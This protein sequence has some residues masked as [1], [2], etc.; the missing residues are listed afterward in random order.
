MTNNDG[1]EPWSHSSLVARHSSL[2][3]SPEAGVRAAALEWLGAH[4]PHA[5]TAAHA[6]LLRDPELAVRAAAAVAFR[7][8]PDP[9]LANG[10]RRALRDLITGDLASRYAGLRVAATLANPFTIPRLLPFLQDPDPETR[11]LTLLALATPPPGL[12]APVLVEAA[13]RPLLADPEPG[14]R[15]AAR[16][17][18]ATVR[19]NAEPATPANAPADGVP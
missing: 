4:A 9:A 14:V 12:V 11:R 7:A 8:S 3:G 5:L 1:N 6:H 13:A 18:L 2:L 10:A 15:D 17:L 16:D 19:R